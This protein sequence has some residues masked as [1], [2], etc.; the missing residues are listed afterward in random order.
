MTKRPAARR[1]APR[2][3]RAA[4]AGVVVLGLPLSGCGTRA[5]DAQIT[6]GAVHGGQVTLTQDSLA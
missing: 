4:A 1:H 2:R 5:D 6:A 3:T